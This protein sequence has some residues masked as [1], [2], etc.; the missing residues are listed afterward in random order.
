MRILALAL[1]ALTTAA[2]LLAEDPAKFPVG[3]CEFTRPADWKWIQP[4][5][6]MRKAQLQI[7]G[8]EGGKPA[9]VTFFFFGDGQGG[10]V[11]ANVQRWLGQFTGKPDANKVQPQEFNGVKVT[12]VSA[13][14]TMKASPFGGQPDDQPDSALLG[15]I[16]EQPGGAVFVKLTGPLDLVKA[17]NDKFVAMV[18]TATEKK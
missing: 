3:P 5:S 8:K 16:I 15:A 9:D 11:Q 18:K 1:C 6:P 7:P 17:S 14:G 13:E 2:T 12:L 10:D 4:S